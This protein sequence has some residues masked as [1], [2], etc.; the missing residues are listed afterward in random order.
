VIEVLIVVVTYNSVQYIENCLRSVNETFAVDGKF[1]FLACVVDN[2]SVDGTRNILEKIKSEY[3]WLRIVLLDENVGFGAGNNVA[4]KSYSAGSYFLLNV[5]AYFVGDS[6]SEALK[7]TQRDKNIGV[8]GVPLVYPDGTPQS[9]SFVLSTWHR[10]LLSI[11][12]AR[13][14][15]VWLLRFKFLRYLISKSKYGHSFAVT[16]SKPIVNF[17]K[18]EKLNSSYTGRLTNVD[19]VSGAAMLLTASFVADSGG[20]DEKIFLYGEDEDICITARK[21][22]YSVKTVDTLPIAHFLGWGASEF[23]PQLALLKYQSLRYFIQKNVDGK[24]NRV[25]MR[26]LLPVYVYKWRVTI[27]LFR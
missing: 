5:D 19:W 1:S 25:L 7:A 11:L 17:S 18:F 21:H 20:F 15:L 27:M 26:V 24:I 22:N 3:D 12:G 10:W 9:S 8:L 23:K 4:M 13:S 6:I 14:L 16:H 2:C